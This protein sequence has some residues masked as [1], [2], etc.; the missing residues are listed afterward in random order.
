MSM[1]SLFLGYNLFTADATNSFLMKC[2]YLLSV[3]S[4]HNYV[5]NGQICFSWVT[6]I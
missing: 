5:R 3:A 1:F 6:V 4:C 2:S